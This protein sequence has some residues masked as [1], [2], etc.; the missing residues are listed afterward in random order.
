MAEDSFP[1]WPLYLSLIFGSLYI[2]IAI[3]DILALLAIIQ[4]PYSTGDF[5]ASIMMLVV[6]LVFIAGTPSLRR[7]EKDGYAFTLVATTL[8]GI[9]FLLQILVFISNALGWILGF[10]NWSEWDPLADIIPSIW[11]FT[12]ILLTMGVLRSLKMLGGEKG[13]FPIGGK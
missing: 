11:L 2:L 4:S 1:S 13:I 9:L 10:E 3:I 7:G 8:A 5:I 12:L 6:G